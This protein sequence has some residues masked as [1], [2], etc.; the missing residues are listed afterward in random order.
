MADAIKYLHPLDQLEYVVDFQDVLPTADTSIVD[1]DAGSSITA[2]DSA[3]GD[4]ESVLFDKAKSGKTLK[5]TIKNAQAGEEYAVT[6]LGQGTTSGKRFA[7]V[8]AFRCR[9]NLSGEF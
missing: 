7:R 6:F 8:V 2:L 4:A 1:V 9:T 5:V 3:G